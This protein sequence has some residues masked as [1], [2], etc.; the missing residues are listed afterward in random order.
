MKP[1]KHERRKRGRPSRYS[2]AIADKICDRLEHAEVGLARLL[3]ESPDLPCAKTIWTWMS[4]RPDFLQKITGAKDRQLERMQ[5]R[6]VELIDAVDIGSNRASVALLQAKASADARFK[7]AARIAPRRY[8]SRPDAKVLDSESR[9][10]IIYL[11]DQDR[12]A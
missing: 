10:T 11:D 4:N 1:P 9:P 3:D 8:G 12:Y 7:L 5:Y 2:V 6:A